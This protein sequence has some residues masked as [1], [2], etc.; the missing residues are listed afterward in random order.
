V[1]HTLHM[2]LVRWIAAWLRAIASSD[3]G[4]EIPK[5]SAAWQHVRYRAKPIDDY[6]PRFRY[7]DFVAPLEG[8]GVWPA[9][10][11]EVECLVLEFCRGKPI[12]TIFQ[13]AQRIIFDAPHGLVCAFTP[14]SVPVGLLATEAKTNLWHQRAP[15]KSWMIHASTVPDSEGN[16]FGNLDQMVAFMKSSLESPSSRNSLRRALKEIQ[17]LVLPAALS[18]TALQLLF[19]GLNRTAL[20]L[21]QPL[22]APLIKLLQGWSK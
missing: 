20:G 16:I 4:A 18:T 17:S 14:W 2:V 13:S 1:L 11:A 15:V 10:V 19:P 22:I 7:A 12:E 8:D 6:G 5:I 3:E 21:V 9:S